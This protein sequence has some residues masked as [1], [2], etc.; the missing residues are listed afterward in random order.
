MLACVS[1]TLDGDGGGEAALSLLCGGMPL[2][3]RRWRTCGGCDVD[4]MGSHCGGVAAKTT[5]VV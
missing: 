2:L 3:L 5:L 1:G 4:R